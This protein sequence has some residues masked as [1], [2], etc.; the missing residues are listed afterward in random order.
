MR[1]ILQRANEDSTVFEQFRLPLSVEEWTRIESATPGY[2]A[3][4]NVIS[5]TETNL[6]VNDVLNN[7]QPMYFRL[8]GRSTS[9][10]DVNSMDW[11]REEYRGFIPSTAYAGAGNRNSQNYLAIA[12]DGKV[13]LILFSPANGRLIIIDKPDII[14]DPGPTDK[15][16]KEEEHILLGSGQV[17]VELEPEHVQ[18]FTEQK[19]NPL[20]SDDVH[21]LTSYYLSGSTPDQSKMNYA[22]GVYNKNYTDQCAE[23]QF[24]IMYADYE[25]KGDRD[26]G[27]L[28]NET[29]TKALYTQYSNI[30]LPQ[31]QNK[32]NFNGEDEDYVYIIKVPAKRFKTTMDAGNWQLTLSSANFASNINTDSSLS[33]LSNATYAS[34]SVTLIDTSVIA[35]EPVS[36]TTR[37][38][39]VRIGT[40][41]DGLYINYAALPQYT[42]SAVYISGSIHAAIKGELTATSSIVMPLGA[43]VGTSVTGSLSGVYINL[44]GGHY[45]NSGSGTYA[46]TI[47]A[48]GTVS[49]SYV[50]SGIFTG[51]GKYKGITTGSISSNITLIPRITDDQA[52][53][54]SG[55]IDFGSEATVGYIPYTGSFL[56]NTN[57]IQGSFRMLTVSGSNLIPISNAGIIGAFYTDDITYTTYIPLDLNNADLLT[58]Y[59]STNEFFYIDAFFRIT[60]NN[61]GEFYPNHGIIVLSGKKMDELGFNTNR[62]IERN[63]LNTYRLYRS[64]KLVCDNNFTD[65]SG[66]VLGFYGRSVDIKHNKLCFIRVNSQ[67]LN[68]S[69]NPT[70]VTGESGE[71]IDDFKYKNKSLFT[72]V[73]L[74]NEKKELL[75]IGK[76][77]TV[78]QSALTKESLFKVKIGI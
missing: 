41:E 62:S 72:S 66:D 76:I 8:Y 10:Y 12:P 4:G 22:L 46:G 70:Y 16:N 69:N 25:G 54:P 48:L 36:L 50:V 58:V 45:I 30:L 1:I 71:I 3:Y 74:Y 19:S 14:T 49:G 60:K 11:S 53:M 18:S 61:Y 68:Y 43:T 20:W 39:D 56:P 7:C 2:P 21:V 77:S 15:K 13:Y 35:K 78:M 27:G 57:E 6:T 52:Y 55:S 40:I 23:L 24:Q 65:D 42:S 47:T 44:G 37:T 38:Y 67:R 5:Y 26:L 17:F 73:G 31:G 34:E 9:N 51:T 29:I 59:N 33:E 64:M 75:A 63:G 32:F 28:D